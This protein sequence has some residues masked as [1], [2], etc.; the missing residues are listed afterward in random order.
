MDSLIEW[1]SEAIQTVSGIVWGWPAAM[2]LLV[3]LLVGTG[4][5]TTFRLGWI[6]V[7]YFRHGLRVIRGEY[8]DP[9]HE[10]DLSHFQALTTALSATVGIGNIAGVATAI[11]Y[12]G[13]GALFWMWVTAVF[14][15]ALKFT[16]CTLSMKTR[17][18]LPGGS[19]AGGPMYSIERGLG[20][21]W[22]PL[23][24]A[25]ACFAVISSFGSGNAVQSFTVADQFRQ[26]LGVPTWVTGLVLASL[27][28]AV[29]LGGIRRIGRVTSKL[30]PFMAALY[31]GSAFVVLVLNI[32]E[33]PGT[34]AM[35]FA[36]A[37]RPAA[38]IGGFAGGT[39]IFMLTWGVK[40]GLFSNES[41]QGSAP[42]AHAAAKTDEPIREGVVAM[43]G[44]FIDTLVICTMTGLVILTSGVWQEKQQQQLLVNEQSAIVAV[45]AGSDVQLNGEIGSDDLAKGAF[46][47]SDGKPVAFSLIR[48]HALVDDAEI[49]IADDPVLQRNLRAFTGSLT[50]DPEAGGRLEEAT[51]LSAAGGAEG[52]VLV[53]R[54]KAMQNG[55]PLTAW[56]F[57]E[58]LGGIA[59]G[60][61]HLL[62]TMAVF[63]FGLSTAISWSYYGDRSILYLAGPRWVMPYRV[64]FCIAH[65]LGAVYSLELVWAF[66]DMALGLMTI[67]NLISI[68]LL[69]GLVK[70]WVGEYVIEGKLEPPKG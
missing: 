18:I 34:L 24:V 33:V 52:G 46:A 19:A 55:S 68:L 43:I 15:M 21:K 22:K 6:Q 40:R 1:V 14:G 13:P 41:G 60:N 58:G 49:L 57:R 16:E 65:F 48:N 12:G 30:V 36:S 25:F 27:V 37:F 50:F 45:A 66:G 10:G 29:I 3:V 59:F 51:W 35:I 20:R 62:V 64:V 5:V 2:P 63:F 23:A 31:V 32:Q 26:D 53:L 70:G 47:V 7:R 28:A 42:I 11:H 17:I 61:G 8:D 4:L 39:F 69:T 38:Q 44:P 9:E 67:P 54:G 56:A